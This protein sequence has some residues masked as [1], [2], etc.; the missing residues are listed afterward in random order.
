MT[1]PHFLLRYNILMSL[2]AAF[3]THPGAAADIR[4]LEEWCCVTP[5]ELNWN[6]AYLEKCGY[7]ELGTS[8]G[9][10]PYIASM[11]ALTA[12]GID[13]AEDTDACKKRFNIT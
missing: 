4:D 12:A 7:V 11:V 6:L 9:F 3:K 8:E 5:D 1:E 2:Y 10:P 13:L